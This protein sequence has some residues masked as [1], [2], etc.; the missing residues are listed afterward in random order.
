MRYKSNYNPKA[1]I[2]FEVRVWF[3]HTEPNKYCHLYEVHTLL[4]KQE[5]E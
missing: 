3:G 5:I 2:I 1:A 4:R